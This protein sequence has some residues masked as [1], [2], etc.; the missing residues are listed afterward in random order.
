ML[1]RSFKLF[2]AA[3]ITAALCVACGGGGGSAAPAP[4]GLAVVPGDTVATLNWDMVE[5]V[6]YWVFDVP[7][8]G[9]PASTAAMSTWIG[10]AGGA[11]FVKATSPFVVSG[12]VDGTSYSFSVNGR[13]NGGP[14]GPGAAPVVATPLAP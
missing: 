9:A 14:G 2:L 3:A 12:L 10:V 1:L 7:T 6:E 11:T 13:T 5:G 8:S 4:T